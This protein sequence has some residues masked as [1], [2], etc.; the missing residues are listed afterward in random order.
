MDS[1]NSRTATSPRRVRNLNQAKAIRR[2]RPTAPKICRTLRQVGR[3]TAHGVR[4]RASPYDTSAWR[5]QAERIPVT[6]HPAKGRRP[7]LA[8]DPRRPPWSSRGPDC[9][10]SARGRSAPWAERQP[11][12]AS[13]LSA[14]TLPVAVPR[15]V[16]K[17][18]FSALLFCFAKASWGSF[19]SSLSFLRLYGLAE[20]G[21]IL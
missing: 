2:P 15:S 10:P 9:S 14:P 19:A 6:A 5:G 4:G 20:G 7:F 17:S 8:A 1:K 13:A 18:L 3:P 16:S 11:V 12:A 21:V